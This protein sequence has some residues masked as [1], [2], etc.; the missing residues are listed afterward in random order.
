VRLLLFD[1]DGTLLDSGGAGTR[2]LDFAF[3]DIFSIEDAFRG[4]SMAGKTDLQ[5]IRE[6]LTKHRLP[7]GNGGIPGIIDAYLAH[8]SAEIG[9]STKRLK[10]GIREALTA[11]GGKKSE[12]QLGLLTGNLEPGARIKLGAFGINEYFPSGAFG[13]DHED[14]NQL[15][16]IAVERFRALC[17][18]DFSYEQC[19]IIGDTPRD[20]ACARPYGAFC[21][22]VATGPYNTSSL[23]EAGAD[24][25]VEDLSDTAHLLNLLSLL[26]H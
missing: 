7:S 17:G 8:L 13:S 2:S 9:T 23:S 26:N 5:I 6:G 25:V 1:I 22:A 24:I 4:I 16:P 3:R 11:L 14:R 21:I 15:L 18:R 12:F 10:P 20:V 19:I